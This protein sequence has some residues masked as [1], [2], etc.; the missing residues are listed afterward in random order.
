MGK[1][2]QRIWELKK[3]MEA[4]VIAIPKEEAAHQF[5]QRLAGAAKNEDTRRM[6]LEL[7]SEELGHKRKLQKILVAVK[8]ELEELQGK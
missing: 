3:K 5:Y 7:A 1:R 4:I 6:F 8:A 2:E